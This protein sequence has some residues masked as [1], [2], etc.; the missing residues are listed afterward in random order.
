MFNVSPYVYIADTI[1]KNQSFFAIFNVF[2]SV[3]ELFIYRILIV[4]DFSFSIFSH[5][6]SMSSVRFKALSSISFSF[7][8]SKFFPC[9]FYLFVG[10]FLF[11]F[12]LFFLRMVQS[13]LQGGMLRYVFLWWNFCCRVWFRDV[14]LF[15][16]GI[17][18]LTFSFIF[19]F[20]W[21]CPLPIS[22]GS[23]NFLFL[24]VF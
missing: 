4:G 10:C 22:P 9:F 24:K 8:L 12:F 15:F 17:F 19:F 13:I 6:Q 16:W 20:I 18:L 3:L 5:I 11:F 7:G 1:F 2:L 23:C 21:W 14:F